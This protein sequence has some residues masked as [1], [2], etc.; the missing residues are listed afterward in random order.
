MR[1]DPFRALILLS[2]LAAAPLAAQDHGHPVGDPSELGVVTFPT[3][4]DAAVA[5]RFEVAVAMLHSF[6]FGPA[7]D[8]FRAIAEADPSCGMARWGVAVTLMGNPMTRALPPAGRL[9]D[10]LAAAERAV[11]LAAEAS[12]RERMYAEAALAY[13]ATDGDFAA[14]MTAHESAMDAL[15][16]AHPDDPEATIFYARAVVANAPPEDLT[17]ERQIYAAELMRPLFEATPRHPGLAHYIIHAYDAPALAQRGRDAAFAYADI[18]PAAPHALHMPSHI[19]TRLGYWDE[20]IETNDRSA[21]AS[22]D[23]DAA[24]HPLDYMVYAYLQQG[25]D[26]AAAAVVERAGGEHDEFYG[27]LLGYNAVAMPARLALERGDWA[28]AAR[29]PVPG[30]ALPYVQAIARFTRALGHARADGPDAGRTADL[31]AARDETAAL[32]RLQADLAGAG[33]RYW[34]TIVRAQRLAADAWIARAAGDDATALLL[35]RE[36]AG[37]EETVEKHPVTPGP[38][39]PASELLG[40][41]LMQLDRPADALDA[42]RATL[43]REPRRARATYGAARAA[44]AAGDR[45]AAAGYYRALLELMDRADEDRTEVDRARRF[46]AAGG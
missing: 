30:D 27:G 5:E 44:E 16:R 18:A 20:S 3:T 41:L 31:D 2:L 24:V 10:G 32:G 6:W 39:L 11:E 28:A 34:A 23:P 46:L 22:P 45:D 8:E 17:F 1:N 25:R 43:E 7:L 29:L 4:C 14:R 42:Y 12:A 36:A 9:R 21:A 40:D 19:F 33:D 37:V 15:R 35:A 13:Y 26:D 38:L